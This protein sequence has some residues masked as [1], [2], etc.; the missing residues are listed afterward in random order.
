MAK[1]IELHHGFNKKSFLINIDMIVYVNMGIDGSA[2]IYTGLPGDDDNY[3]VF[4][5]METYEEVKRILKEAG[6]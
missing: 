1:F 4:C 5:C 2:E 6:Q 3:T